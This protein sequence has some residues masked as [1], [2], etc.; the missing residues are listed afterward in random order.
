[1]AADP[2]PRTAALPLREVVLEPQALPTADDSQDRPSAA[3]VRRTDS[4]RSRRLGRA[5]DQLS[6]NRPHA[7]PGG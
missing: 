7:C 3:S 4:R 2:A 6:R 5:S 1:M